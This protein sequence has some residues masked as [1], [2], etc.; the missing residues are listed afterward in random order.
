MGSVRALRTS[1]SRCMASVEVEGARA[2]ERRGAFAALFG[3]RS[4]HLIPSAIGALFWLLFAIANIRAS[5][6]SHR[7]IGLGVG[8]LGLWAAILFVVRRPPREVSKNAGVWVVAFLGTF[9]ASLLRPGGTDVGWL[10]AVGLGLQGIAIALGAVSMKALGRSLGLVPANRGLVTSGA[11]RV[12]RHPLYA[13]YVF[14]EVGYLLQSPR[15]WNFGVIALVW[16]CQ[17][18]RIVS[19]DR[20]LSH[21]PD[22]GD[23]RTR[24]PWRVIPGIW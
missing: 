5:I 10:D 1:Y 11:Y 15:W 6:D 9:G 13:S 20:L 17:V 23:Y 7:V 3:A 2:V 19:E 18:M 4:R 22:Y 24:T 8:L 21:D 14:A 12:V 16:A